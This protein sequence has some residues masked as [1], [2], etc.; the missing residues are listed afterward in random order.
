[1]Q[2]RKVLVIGGNGFIGANLCTT[3]S[4]YGDKVFSFDI[5]KPEIRNKGVT[6]IVGDFF[7]DVCLENAIEGM[8]VIIHSLST[9]N[10]GNSN[11]RY[12]QGYSRDFVQSVKLFSMAIEKKIKVVFISS[13]GTVYGDQEIQPINENQIPVPINHYGAV[14][15]CIESVIRTF[16]TQMHSKILIARVS[17]PYGPGQD[18]TKGVGFVDASLKKA[19]HGETI[20]VWGDGENVR[21]YIYIDDVCE[22]IYSLSNYEGS[23]DVFNVSSNEGISLN[24]I[25]DVLRGIGLEPKVN[26]EPS[27][28]VDVRSIVLDNNRILEVYDKK[29]LTFKE[30]LCKYY[31][32]LVNQNEK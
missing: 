31:E 22:M 15:L 30:G 20:H 1:M 9:V 25:L 29:V 14:K 7:D 8:D 3:F 24:K 19:I 13:G 5:Q 26:Y 2:N 23:T 21:D 28:N 16:N 17:N 4:N 32:Y 6:Y 11:E 10:P 18:Y 27:R 12:M